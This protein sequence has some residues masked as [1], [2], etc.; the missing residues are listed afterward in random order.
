M[1]N[2]LWS[3]WIMWLALIDRWPTSE[4][5]SMWIR[6]GV[7]SHGPISDDH[8]WCESYSSSST[9]VY[10]A[11]LIQ[12][13]KMTFDYVKQR[14][15][16]LSYENHFFQNTFSNPPLKFEQEASPVMNLTFLHIAIRLKHW[17]KF[18]RE[19]EHFELWLNRRFSCRRLPG[20]N[21]AEWFMNDY[22]QTGL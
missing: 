21:D 7:T 15:Q 1:T 8:M 20:T 16:V 14:Q 17:V 12:Y 18:L 10:I 22:G 5:R 19:P 11:D 13:L 4:N 2:H 9:T 3:V 6:T